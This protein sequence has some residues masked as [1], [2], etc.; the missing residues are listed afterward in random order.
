MGVAMNIRNIATIAFALLFGLVAV[1]LT[2]FWLGRQRVADRQTAAIE[3]TTPV[4]VAAQPI[5][6]FARCA[7]GIAASSTV[8]R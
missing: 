2:Q 6:R 1:L 5:G 4:V 7:C 8:G 3:G